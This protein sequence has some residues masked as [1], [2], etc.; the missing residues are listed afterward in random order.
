MCLCLC[1][2]V[3]L[4]VSCV[5]LWG[6]CSPPPV[7][8]PPCIVAP[9]VAL[10]LRQLGKMQATMQATSSAVVSRRRPA[11]VSR[12]ATVTV[13]ANKRVQKKSK[14]VLLLNRGRWVWWFAC[15]TGLIHFVRPA[16]SCCSRTLLTLGSRARLS[17]WVEHHRVECWGGCTMEHLQ[18]AKRLVL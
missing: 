14:C 1:L 18:H 16:G 15:M 10:L 9:R 11:V 2:Y 4:F 13:E 6:P 12:K 17:W 5:T 7:V 3:S 8:T